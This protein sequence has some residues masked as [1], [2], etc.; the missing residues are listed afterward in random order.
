MYLEAILLG[1]IQGI[2]E[3]LPISSSAHLV[4]APYFFKFNE[5]VLSS[6]MFDA[7]LHGGSLLSILIYFWKSI[8]E[9]MNKK[10]LILYI[11]VSTI[12][13]F[14]AGFLIE[15]IKDSYLR[16][17]TLI[18]VNMI[19]FSIYMIFSERLH[20]EEL[21]LKD[22]DIKHFIYL[23]IMQSIALIPGTSR[24]G[25]TIATAYL[26][27][28]KKEDAVNVSFLMGIPVISAAFL[29]ELKKALT[30]NTE[31]IM[32]SVLLVGI[33]SSLVFGLLALVFLVKFLKRF[34]FSYFA[35]YRIF[36]AFLIIYHL[37]KI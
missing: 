15:P 27:S 17:V 16:G 19:I 12:P 6:T 26:L 24:S 10:R 33:L 1:A 21:G 29:Y 35:Y 36:V 25:V 4:L 22:L 8:L 3:F 23:G 20:K 34:K 32:G 7:I 2:T 5:Q 30:S 14:V 18:A 9:L 31:I 11:I 37:W 13:T 28:I